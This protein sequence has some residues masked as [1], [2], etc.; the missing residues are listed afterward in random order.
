[1]RSLRRRLRERAGQRGAV[2]VEFAL[3]LFLLV[4]LLIGTLNYGYYF[5][6]AL[7]AVEAANA[8]ARAGASAPGFTNCVT[9]GTAAATATAAINAEMQKT[10]LPMTEWTGPS[11]TGITQS[12]QIV[13]TLPC[14]SV[15]IRVDFKPP[16]PF[17]LAFMP[18]GSPTTKTR[19]I[20]KTVVMP[21]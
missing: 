7:H 5:W 15:R 6:V 10:G 12:C 14:W 17:M 19:F 2:A 16:V 9:L 11:P 18:T 1:M 8:G 20:T 3:S 4:P 13:D 21:R